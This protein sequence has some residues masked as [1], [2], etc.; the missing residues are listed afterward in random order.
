MTR[1]RCLA[2]IATSLAACGDAHSD[3]VASERPPSPS[4]AQL[5][6]NDVAILF[7]LAVTDDGYLSPSSRGAAGE[8]IPREVYEH[9]FGPAGS[10]MLGGTPPAPALDGLR[11]VA[12]RFDPCFAALPPIEA[13]R[14]VAQL[15]LVFQ[16]IHFD[17]RGSEATDEAVH[18]FYTLDRRQ[19]DAAT[20]EL[21]ALRHDR[22]LGALAPH[23]IIVDEGMTG[24]LATAVS[25]IV[26]RHAGA[27]NLSRITGITSSGLGTAW[28]FFGADIARGSATPIAIPGLPDARLEAFF[29]GFTPGALTGDPAITPRPQLATE[30]DLFVLADPE[31][32]RARRAIDRIEN[33]TIHTANTIDCASCHLAASF[34]AMTGSAGGKVNVHMFGYAGRTPSIQPRTIREVDTTLAYLGAADSTP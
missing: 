17:P 28:N 1:R 24:E 34:R 20:A 25:R 9:A 7:P 31:P 18:A 14:C 32:E 19:L 5:E 27:E 29:A 22:K 12:L 2:A 11:V 33:P 13:A 26:L 4:K 16:T 15:R 3:A 21:A 30:D 23:P 10:T 8:L 6:P